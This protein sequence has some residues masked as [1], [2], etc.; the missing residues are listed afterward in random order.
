MS[1]N[2]LGLVA[3]SLLVSTVTT[4]RGAGFAGLFVRS[5]EVAAAQ[6]C[7]NTEP[8]RLYQLQSSATLSGTDW[9]GVGAPV[10]GTGG[11]MCVDSSVAALPA[12]CFYRIMEEGGDTNGAAIYATIKI[13]KVR[14]CWETATNLTYQLQER[15]ES[16]GN[17][18]TDVGPVRVATEPT[19][20]EVLRVIDPPRE[21]R[22]VGPEVS[23]IPAGT[24]LMGSPPDEPG[25][26]SSEGPQT[27]VT[28]SRGFW[29][30]KY[31]VT[32]GEYVEVMGSMSSNPSYFKGDLN[33][34]VE[35]VTWHDATNY[36]G[37]LT[38]RERSA[39]RIPGG[40]GYRLP[41]EAEWEYACRAGTTTR[42][43]Y[44]DDLGYELLGDF[45]WY[46]HNSGATTHPVGQKRPNPWGLYDMHGNV[47]ERCQDWYEVFYPGGAV[48]DPTGPAS[49]SNR[50]SRG[51]TWFG[52][53]G[54]CRSAYRSWGNPTFWFVDVGF[55]V[56]LA[57]VPEN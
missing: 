40:Y 26:N 17:V 9:G 29:M 36:C 23:W 5:S 28:I 20:C 27:T 49:S 54:E 33:R 56:V 38:S 19:T 43:S 42:F 53:G 47:W 34:P 12:H 55:R 7:W 52:G 31:E 48:S 44:G 21:Y 6:I 51:G 24:F 4:V 37:V 14:L 10:A 32:Q 57:V 45:G 2:L 8:G 41:T 1:A 22:L 30:G 39:G 15:S 18:W 11:T 13:S 35:Q 16:S 25:R 3:A 46:G 50:V